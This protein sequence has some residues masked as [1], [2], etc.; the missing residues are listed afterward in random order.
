MGQAIDVIVCTGY[1][2]YT[3]SDYMGYDCVK[4]FVEKPLDIDSILLAL[5]QV[6]SDQPND[7]ISANSK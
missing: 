6:A 2:T 3:R 4:G 1:S 5:I 7:S